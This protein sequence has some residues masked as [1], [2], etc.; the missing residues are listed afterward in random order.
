MKFSGIFA[1]ILSTLVWL[2][3]SFI[4]QSNAKAYFAPKDEMLKRSTYILVV[5][6]KKVEEVE[7]K[8]QH[9]TYRQKASALIKKQL[10]GDPLPKE[11]SLYGQETFICAQVNFTTGRHL[12]FLRKDKELLTGSNWHLSVRPISK[13][14]TVEWYQGQSVWDLKETPLTQVLKELEQ[15]PKN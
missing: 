10:K 3:I 14:N 12:L 2:S 15:K 11:I 6:I 8:G 9:W 4:T 5:N 7:T 1:I 13:E